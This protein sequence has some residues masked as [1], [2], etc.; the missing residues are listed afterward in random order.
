MS[1][2]ARSPPTVRIADPRG[3]LR[4]R[5]ITAAARAT[6]RPLA[7]AA[8][9]RTLAGNARYRTA[10]LSAHVPGGELGLA[11]AYSISLAARRR[12]CRARSVQTR[13]QNSRGRPRRVG[14]GSCSPHTAQIAARI[15]RFSCEARFP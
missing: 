6:R 11:C 9:P 5:A 13:E 1:T 2:V 4:F 10:D 8:A 14:A 12:R 15:K 7:P 3:H